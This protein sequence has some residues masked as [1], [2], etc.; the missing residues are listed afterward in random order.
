MKFKYNQWDLS[1]NISNKYHKNPTYSERNISCKSLSMSHTKGDK[2]TDRQTDRQADRQT[3]KHTDRQRDK[4][5]R[6]HSFLDCDNIRDK[7]RN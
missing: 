3:N 2:Q 6:S 1:S 4:A 5:L 7:L